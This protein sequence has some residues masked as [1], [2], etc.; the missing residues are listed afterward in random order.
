MQRRTLLPPEF[1]GFAFLEFGLG[2]PWAQPSMA[3]LF[4]FTVLSELFSSWQLSPRWGKN[5][6][7]RLIFLLLHH[8]CLLWL[9]N[10]RTVFDALTNLI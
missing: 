4:K 8:G 2:P 5:T 6:F 3:S 7:S 10:K 9:A 1:A